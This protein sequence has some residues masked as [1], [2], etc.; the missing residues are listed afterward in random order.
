MVTVYHA[1]NTRSIRVL[2]VLE[3]LG[4]KAEIKSLPYPPRKLHFQG[5]RSCPKPIVRCM[6]AYLACW[7]LLGSKCFPS[8]MHGKRSRAYQACQRQLLQWSGMDRFGTRWRPSPVAPPVLI[9]S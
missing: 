4:V 8:L 5:V 7:L 9:A 1:P 6:I 2:W 3:E